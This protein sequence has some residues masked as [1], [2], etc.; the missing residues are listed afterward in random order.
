[1]VK[2]KPE[3]GHIRMESKYWDQAEDIHP[4]YKLEIELYYFPNTTTQFNT[5]N[6]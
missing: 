2:I 1:M 4:I 5:F 3:K 6:L